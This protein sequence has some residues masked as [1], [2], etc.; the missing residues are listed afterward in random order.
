MATARQE[1]AFKEVVE[2]GRSVSAAMRIAGLS[3]KTAIT[4][5]KLTRS[6]GWKELMD[7]YFPESKLAEL[8]RKLLDKQEILIIS[9]GAKE[10]SHMEKTGQPHTDALKA[11]DIALKLRAR[12]PTE[13]TMGN[14]TL[15]INITGETASRYKILPTLED[16]GQGI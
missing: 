14:K 7:K 13:E 2:N 1:I 10:G 5:S 16:K 6:K 12:Y 11:L 4:P 9:D 3:P 15:I 8:H